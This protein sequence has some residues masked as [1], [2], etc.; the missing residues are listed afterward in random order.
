MKL[1]ILAGGYGT[2]L[3]EETKTKPKPLVKIGNKPIIWHLMKIYSSFG[4]NE[5]IICLGYKGTMIR[6]E[7]KKYVKKESWLINF[8]DTG[9]HTMTGG[10]VKRI[11]KY[12]NNDK[13]FCLS[14][15]DGLSNINIK[16]LIKFHL[17]NNKI[18]TLTAVKYK[19]P[20]GVLSIDKSS[21]INKI[22]E[23]PVEYINGG[24]FVLSKKIFKYLKNNNTIFEKDCLPLLAK[25]KQLIAFKHNDFWACMDTIRE[26]KELNTLWKTKNCKWKVW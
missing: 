1:V 5:F 25:K 16:K 22:K 26:K 7:L 20:K 15:G 18:A 6:D 12:L 21:K 8:V 23:K 24:F 14:Y 19:N 13:D 11:K 2:R 17:N 4:I 10:R 9:L 3:S